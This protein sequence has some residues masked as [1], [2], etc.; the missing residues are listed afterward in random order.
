MKEE[1]KAHGIEV[2]QPMFVSHHE[3]LFGQMPGQEKQKV[4]SVT[5]MQD[6]P[7]LGSGVGN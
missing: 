2:S 6:F 1:K 7:T 3:L 5:S 4:V